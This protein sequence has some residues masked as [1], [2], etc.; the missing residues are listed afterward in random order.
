MFNVIEPLRIQTSHT[1]VPIVCITPIS[2]N[3]FQLQHC[4]TTVSSISNQC[5]STSIQP[6]PMSHDI[7]DQ[8]P[9]KPNQTKTQQYSI[10]FNKFSLP[11]QTNTP[12]PNYT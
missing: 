5:P 12:K 3:I 10:S 9:A 4:Y 1:C 11:Q 2:N 6:I 7:I 8:F